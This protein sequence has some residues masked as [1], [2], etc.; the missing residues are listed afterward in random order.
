MSLGKAVGKAILRF[1]NNALTSLEEKIARR[2]AY[3]ETGDDFVV[4]RERGIYI[5]GSKR[6]N[7]HLV[8]NMQ[9][10]HKRQQI[11]NDFINDL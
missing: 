9:S 6:Y 4:G 5:D 10:V 3:K 8:R 11:R 2:R 7:K 1:G